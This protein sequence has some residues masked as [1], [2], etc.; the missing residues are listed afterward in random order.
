MKKLNGV[1]FDLDGTLIDSAPDIRQAINLTLRDH[2]RRALSLEETLN[3]IGDGAVLLV[4]RALEAT[5]GQLPDDIMPLVQ[6]YISHYRALPPDPAQIFPGVLETLK[7]LRD[8]N[9]ALGVCTN[10]AESATLKL[11]DQLNLTR[12]FAGIAGADTFIAHKPDPIHLTGTMDLMGVETSG[13]VMVGDG[14]NDILVARGAGI[15]CIRVDYGYAFTQV[16]LKADAVIDH[17]DKLCQTLAGLG[18][19]L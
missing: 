18:F 3:F 9:I 4:R 12:F 17:M 2:G 19:S 13:C 15:P 14:P 8:K 1:V 7:F 5:G 16:N 6:A 10:K 11:L